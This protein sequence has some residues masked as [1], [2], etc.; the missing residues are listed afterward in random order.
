MLLS[1]LAATPILH[2]FVYKL[3]I[4]VGKR[5]DGLMRR[6]WWKVSVAKQCHGQ[7]LV[8]WDSMCRPIQAE[9]LGILNI[10][11]MNTTLRAS[12]VTKLMNS[13]E[14]LVT[15][16]LKESNDRGLNWERYAAQFQG[17]SPLWQGLKNIFRRMQTF[18]AQL[19]VGAAFNI[20]LK[21]GRLE[22]S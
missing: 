22:A 12:Q 4:G 9:G 21:T 5:I 2:L 6:F 1:M 15:P 3:P 8:S 7:A 11:I 16:V 14:D 10:E 19:G 13:R 17:A 18:A 20:G